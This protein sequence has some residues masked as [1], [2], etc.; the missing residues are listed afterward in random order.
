MSLAEDLKNIVSG[1]VLSDSK[2]LET[3]SKDASLFKVMPEVVVCPKDVSDIK[4]VVRFVGEHKKDRPTLSITGRSAGT[5]MSGGPLNESIIVSCT[6]HINKGEAD[7]VSMTARVEPGLYYHDFEGKIVPQDVVFPSYPASKSIAALGGIIMNNAGGEKT[8]RYGQTRDSVLEVKMVLADGNEYAFKKLNLDELEAKKK[9]QTFEGEVYRK[10]FDLLEKNY[11]VVKNARPA[12]SKNSAGYALWRVWDRKHFDLSQLFVGSQ[13]TLGIF[14]QAKIKLVRE[15][16]HKKMVAIFF[17]N[18]DAL[19]GIVNTLLPFEPESLEAFDEAT[20]KLGLRFMPEI[21][22]KAHTSFL[23]FAFQFLPEA[24]MGIR[25]LGMPKLIL[26]AEFAEDDVY[27]LQEK[28][29]KTEKALKAFPVK[30]RTLHE[31]SEQ[32]KYWVMRRE[33]FNLLRQ[34]VKGKRTAPFVEDFCIDPKYIPEF[35]PQILKI[36][37]EHDIQANI[38]GHAGNGNFHIIPLM[39]LTKQ[40]ERDKIVIVADKVHALINHFK[41]TITAEHNDGILRTPY[42]KDMY[43]EKVYSLFEEIKKI[44]D[45]QNIF[46]PGKKVGGTKEY[47]EKHIA[48]T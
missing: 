26:L 11:D 37:K 12:V 36:L 22:K 28:I 21:A 15:K 17:K 34:H 20:L 32:D 31:Q 35:L 5:C 16:P 33:S 29:Q 23:K 27:V 13:G 42:L 2:T 46:N 43:G 14:T 3:Y 10:T 47:L 38:A 40:S 18:W 25:M 30:T 6:Q 1:E 41:G 19:P 24:L 44:Y 7:L 48:T 9:E 4:N 39:D 45:P 8:L